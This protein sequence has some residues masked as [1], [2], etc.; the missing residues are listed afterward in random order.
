[1]YSLFHSI[2]FCFVATMLST[3]QGA[4][5]VSRREKKKEKELDREIELKRDRVREVE[6]ERKSVVNDKVHLSCTVCV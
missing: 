5:V 4:K 2:T 1:M 3:R 6:R